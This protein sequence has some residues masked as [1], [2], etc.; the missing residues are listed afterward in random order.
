[1][2]AVTFEQPR[3]DDTQQ[4]LLWKIASWM[5]PG[6]GN[7]QM[8]SQVQGVGGV[9]VGGSPPPPPAGL[10]EPPTELVYWEDPAHPAGATTDL[11]TFLATADQ[12][13]VSTLDFS[14]TGVTGVNNLYTLPA[15]TLVTAFG[16]PLLAGAMDLH[17]L[18]NLAGVVT[19]NT[20]LTSLNLSGC[21]GLM[22]FRST[23]G[24]LT[25]LDITGCL[26]VTQILLGHNRFAALDVSGHVALS[27][28]DVSYNLLGVLTF[29]GDTG[30]T[31]LWVNNNPSFTP[32][33]P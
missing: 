8:Q 3:L 29:T 24:L 32:I 27:I 31:Q 7:S 15:L 22:T 19:D 21:A 5:S 1:M 16:C 26:A 6:A 13:L 14:G 30:L 12:A 25:T 20:Q 2:S 23:N 28:L 4:R 9:V 17:G 11:P 18:L 33:G 10:W